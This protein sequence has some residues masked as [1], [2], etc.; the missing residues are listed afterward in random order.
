M[1]WFLKLGKRLLRSE[2]IYRVNDGTDTNKKHHL[3]T[4]IGLAPGGHY[5]SCGVVRHC[6]SVSL[7][8]TYGKVETTTVYDCVDLISETELTVP[9]IIIRRFYKLRGSTVQL[10]G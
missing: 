2:G 6:I 4:N 5:S 8:M 10:P 3:V 7:M 9:E 1:V